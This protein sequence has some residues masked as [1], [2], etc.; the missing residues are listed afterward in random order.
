MFVR[1]QLHQSQNLQFQ[2]GPK[3]VLGPDVS[4]SEVKFSIRTILSSWSTGENIVKV[5]VIF[6]TG[7][8]SS[9][10]GYPQ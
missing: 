9:I 7:T 2:V 1:I 8:H 3:A 6:I 10:N 5:L 4:A